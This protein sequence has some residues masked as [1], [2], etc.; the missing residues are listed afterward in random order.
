MIDIHTHLWPSEQSPDYMKGYLEKKRQQG[1][2]VPLSGPE[3]LHSMDICGIERAVISTLAFDNRMTN[4]ALAPLHDY[5]KQQIDASNGRLTAFCTVQPFETNALDVIK[6]FLEKS[7]FRG[8]KLHPNIQCFYPD[9]RRLY[10]LYEWL[11]AHQYPILFHTGGIGLS[12]IKDGY[13]A[14]A[15]I[16]NVACDFPKLPVIMGHAGRIHYETTAM[17][18]RKHKNVYADISTNFGRL[19]GREW[20]QLKKLLETV[21]LWSGTTEKLLFGSDHPFYMQD[22]TVSFTRQLAE[23]LTDSDILTLEDIEHLLNQNAERFCEIY[24]LFARPKH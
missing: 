11:E 10:F 23:H 5:V 4:Q 24:R 22:T 1:K 15:H 6:R 8:L 18:L 3:L 7:G 2:S 9:D 21:K 12:G 20:L 13:G 14:P 17:L 16:D 19:P